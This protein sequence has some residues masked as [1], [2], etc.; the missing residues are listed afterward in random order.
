[1]N[2]AH[3]EE[4]TVERVDQVP[5]ADLIEAGFYESLGENFRNRHNS[6]RLATRAH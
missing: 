3:R 2:T 1:M 4:K 6:T 5:K